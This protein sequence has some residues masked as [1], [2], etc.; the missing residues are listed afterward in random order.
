MN[1]NF[2]QLN[3]DKTEVIIIGAKAKRQEIAAHLS[4]FSLESKEHCWN[5][6]VIIDADLNFHCHINNVT[7]SAFYHFKNISKIRDFLSDSDAEKLVHAF[8]TSD[9]TIAMVSFLDSPK[10]CNA[11]AAYT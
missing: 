7:K 2:L 8:V 5:L 1:Q 6:G 3:S 9:L 4:S 11:T 10:N